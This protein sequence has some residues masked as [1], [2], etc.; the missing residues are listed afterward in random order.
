VV[1][2]RFWTDK[3]LKKGNVIFVW[4]LWAKNYRALEKPEIFNE[5]GAC[6]FSGHQNSKV[7]GNMG[8]TSAFSAIFRFLFKNIAFLVHFS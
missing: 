5:S 3:R 8:Q 1:R 4:K 7:S 2:G 6:T